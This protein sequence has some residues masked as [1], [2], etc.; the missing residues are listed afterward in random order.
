LVPDVFATVCGS[1]FGPWRDERFQVWVRAGGHG[2][3]SSESARVN[4]QGGPDRADQLAPSRTFES[5]VTPDAFVFTARLS[6]ASHAFVTSRGDGPSSSLA[7]D[8][9]Q[10]MEAYT[11]RTDYALQIATTTSIDGDPSGCLV[12]FVTQ[13]SIVPP[14]L[15]VCIS[16][17]NHTYFASEQSDAI[18]VHLIGQDQIALAS[19]FAE[20]SGDTVDKFDLCDWK[21]GANGAPVLSDCVAWLETKV[22]ERWSV[23]DHQALLVRPVAGGPGTHRHLLTA[24]GAPNFSPGHPANG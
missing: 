21:F 7:P 6:G 10:A 1:G 15:L 9:T 14:R 20:T 12:G 5:A 24:R 23:G 16:K 17:V 2:E 13:C 19:L 11:G 22:I 4:E 8:I 18:T 3:Y